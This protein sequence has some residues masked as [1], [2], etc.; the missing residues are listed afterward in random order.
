MKKFLNWTKN[1]ILLFT[2]FVIVTLIGC[3]FLLG[4]FNMGFRLSII[5]FSS[6]IMVIGLVVGT[7]QLFRKKGKIAKSVIIIICIGIMIF[8]LLFWQIILLLLAFSY[9]PEHVV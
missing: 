2:I 9:T 4:I 3:H 1:N 6:I 7:I 5:Y 8:C